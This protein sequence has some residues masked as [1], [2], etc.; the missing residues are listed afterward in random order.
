MIVLVIAIVEI[1]SV[2]LAGPELEFGLVGLEL[3]LELVV[4]EPEL[5]LGLELDYGLWQKPSRIS[6]KRNDL[7]LG[8]INHHKVYAV[9]EID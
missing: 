3:V 2:E 1:E 6:Q 4:L 9:Q 7:G 8:Y 5:G